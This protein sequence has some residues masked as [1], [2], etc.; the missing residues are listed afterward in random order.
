MLTLVLLFVPEQ[1]QTL[2]NVSNDLSVLILHS[3]RSLSP[4]EQEQNWTE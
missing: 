3:G 1:S 2:K 4:C